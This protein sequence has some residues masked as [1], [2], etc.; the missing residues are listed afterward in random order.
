MEMKIL[1]PLDG[2]KIGEAAIPY[3]EDLISKLSAEI[4]IEVVLLQVLSKLNQMV[5]AGEAVAVIQLS[6]SEIRQQENQALG[7]LNKV[8]EALKEKGVKISAKV[9]I[10]EAAE[11]IVNTSQ[12][13]DADMIAMSTHGRSGLSRWA[14]GSVTDKV[15]RMGGKVPILTVKAAQ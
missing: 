12:E 15:L 14:F 13:M 6:E 7:Y 5:A 3:V 2:S 11:V 4:M 9:G 1:V 8:G 10:G